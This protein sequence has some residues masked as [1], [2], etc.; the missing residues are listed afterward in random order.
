MDADLSTDFDEYIALLKQ[1]KTKASYLM[2][3]GSRQSAEGVDIN[4]NPFRLMAAKIS[5]FIVRRIIKLPIIDTQCGAKIFS[6]EA[7][8]VVF[9]KPFETRWLFDVEV[10]VR[11]QQHFGM[12]RV[13]EDI[14]E[15]FVAKWTH[16]PDSKLVLWDMI[17][18]PY[19]FL[20]IFINYK[21]NPFKRA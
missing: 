1:F 3:F 2:V 8:K 7:S 10:I 17:N 4:Y 6:R 12:Q 20:K 18:M 11:L 9:Q 15:F 19:Q 14:H 16:E 13:V 5:R 21:V